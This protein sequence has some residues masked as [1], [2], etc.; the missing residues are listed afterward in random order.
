MFFSDSSRIHRAM[1]NSRE[2]GAFLR[3]N[4]GLQ[5]K[6]EGERNNGDL[7]EQHLVSAILKRR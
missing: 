6:R 4:R 5:M 2:M 1:L 3:S 7:E